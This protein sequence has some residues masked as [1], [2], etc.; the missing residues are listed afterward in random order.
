M[1]IAIT[2][3]SWVVYVI[4]LAVILI[5]GIGVVGAMV[6]LILGRTFI[7]EEDD[8]DAEYLEEE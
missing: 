4:I 2:G 5:L 7:E 8:E 3:L 6:E 1:D